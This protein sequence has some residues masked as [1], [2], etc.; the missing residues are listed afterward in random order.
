[1]RL[2]AGRHGARHRVQPRS[3]GA[4]ARLRDAGLRH[5]HV[6]D[7]DGAFAGKPMN[8]AAVERILETVGLLRAARRRHPRHGDGR[9]L[10]G[11]GRQ[12]RH[13]RHRGG[14]RSGAGEGGGEEIS[15][16]GRGRARRAR[17]QGR[18]RGLGRD[19]RADRARHRQA[20]R[21]RRRRR[22]HLHR[23]RARRH[24]QGPQLGRHHRA[25][26]RDLDSGDRLGRA[27]LDRRREGAD[28][29]RARSKLEGAI[30]GRALY[31]GRLDAGGGAG[32]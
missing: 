15:R 14:A 4:G 18:G 2:A 22:D 17:R 7:L 3:G 21:G 12:P 1:M 32:A 9:G 20:L 31:D 5:L 8:V 25:R 29:S 11:E 10:A 6:V 28:S 27:C 16:A 26:R 30:A 24:A 19:L 13:H 23:R